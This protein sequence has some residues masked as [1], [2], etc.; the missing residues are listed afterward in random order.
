MSDARFLIESLLRIPDKN[1]RD[2]DFILN[3][4]QAQFDAQRTGRDIIAK[5]RQGGFSMYELARALVNCLSER[6][7][8]HVILAHNTDTTQKLLARIHYMIKHLPDRGCPLPSLRHATINRLEFEKTDSSIFIGTA[9]SGDY[10]VGDTITDLH[11]S[12]VSRW[13]NPREILNGLFQSVPPSGNILL[14]STGHG[15]GN[16]FHQAVMRAS[17]GVGYKLHFFNWLN[18]PEYS[19]ELG[20]PGAFLAQLDETLEE[21]RYAK[22]L[23]ANQLAWRRQKLAEFEFDMRL[24]R[25]NYP[26]SLEECFQ[27]T[28]HSLF[29]EVNFVETP[30]WKA[31][32]PWT[33]IHSDHP[34]IG[35]TY[36]CGGDVGAGTGGDYSVLEIFEAETGRQVLEY[37]N[38]MIEPD[39][40]AAKTI[41]LATRYNQA[42]INPERNNMGYLYVKELL[43]TDY[44]KNLIHRAR[45]SNP[46]GGRSQTELSKIS[47]FGTYTTD[48]LKVLMIGGL[49]KHLRLSVHVPAELMI[50][51]Q[52]LQMELSSFV[53]KESGKLEAE[54]GC[55]DD[56][57]MAT[58]LADYC[59]PNAMGLA[60]VAKRNRE[61]ARG[62][63]TI[64]IFEAG[65]AIR[66]LEE[67]F[68]SNEIGFPIESHVLQ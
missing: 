60:D 67:R 9:G 58:A 2:V 36:C 5:Y 7:R 16:W 19:I 65:A 30:L 55:F 39:R 37:R 8:R 31:L 26:V 21:P 52:T 53:E 42:Y 45:F 34:R 49:A 33:M 15:T 23:S 1:G 61:S 63:R 51:S 40:F 29:P 3:Q 54:Q 6:N 22:L 56:C 25:E 43:A 14:E 38:N 64:E 50:H 57:V 11:C 32:D 44:P 66:E 13:P 47:D 20:D 17:R 68:R 27:G 4:D 10:G 18:T 24:F 41:E 46:S 12:E 35:L 48:V 62:R 28:G 59:R